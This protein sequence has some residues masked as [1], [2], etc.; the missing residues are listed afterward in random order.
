LVVVYIHWFLNTGFSLQR[1]TD[2]DQLL[3]FF[4]MEVF[5]FAFVLAT[6]ALFFWTGFRFQIGRKPLILESSANGEFDSIL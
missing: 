1:L 5:Q 6:C 4:T 3:L 2:L